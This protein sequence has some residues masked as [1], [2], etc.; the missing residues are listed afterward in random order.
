MGLVGIP[1][2]SLPVLAS[3]GREKKKTPAGEDPK[4]GVAVRLRESV[5]R[6]ASQHKHVA[7]LARFAVEHIV[8]CH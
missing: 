1:S 4:V 2:E 5:P 6:S 8:M 3:D 7:L